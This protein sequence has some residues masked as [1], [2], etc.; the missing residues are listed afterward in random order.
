[1]VG[2]RSKFLKEQKDECYY[3]RECIQE[4]GVPRC[5]HAKC[6]ARALAVR[7]YYIEVSNGMSSTDAQTNLSFLCNVPLPRDS[8]WFVFYSVQTMVY[9]TGPECHEDKE[10]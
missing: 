9:A 1:M 4:I 5:T 3:R 10:T 8:L 7:M 2:Q 6:D